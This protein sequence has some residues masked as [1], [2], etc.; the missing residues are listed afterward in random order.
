MFFSVQ[1]SIPIKNFALPSN[2]IYSTIFSLNWVERILTDLRPYSETFDAWIESNYKDESRLLRGQALKEALEWSKERILSP[3]DTNFLQTSQE[4]VLKTERQKRAILVKAKKKADQWIRNAKRF[5]GFGVILLVASLIIVSFLWLGL[6]RQNLIA[7]LERNGANALQQF[8]LAPIRALE[9]AIQNGRELKS[10]QGNSEPSNYLATNPILALQTIIDNISEVTEINTYQKG[11]KSVIFFQYGND[12]RLVAAGEDGTLR[13]WDANKGMQIGKELFAHPGGV[14]SVRFSRDQSK[15]VTAG[16]DGMVKLWSLSALNEQNAKPISEFKAHTSSIRNVRYSPNEELIATGGETDGMLKLWTSDGKRKWEVIAHDRGIESL[17]FSPDGAVI[18]TGGEDGYAKK[19]DLEGNLKQTFKHIEDDGFHG[20]VNSVTFSEKDEKNVACK[21]DKNSIFC[22]LKDGRMIATAGDNGTVKI[23]NLQGELLKTINAHIGTV[24]ASRFSIDNTQLATSS[25]DDFTS[26]NQSS[27]RIWNLNTGELLSEFN[28]H[29]GSVE[30]IRYSK[31]G[32]YLATSGKD[33]GKIIKWK[34]PITPFYGREEQHQGQVNSVRFSPDGK[35]IVTAGDDGTVRLWEQD[36]TTLKWEWEKNLP[37]MT[38][39][40]QVKFK[41]VRFNPGKPNQIAI[42]GS[43]GK[44]IIWDLIS[45]NL[46]NTIET[47]QKTIESI[48]FSSKGTYLASTG[49]GQVVQ[50]WDPNGKLIHNYDLKKIFQSGGRTYGVRFSLDEDDEKLAVVGDEGVAVLIDR[51]RG[52]LVRLKEESKE[53][54][55]ERPKGTVYAVG[56]NPDGKTFATAGDDGTIRQWD[57][58]GKQVGKGIDT[59]QG[60]IRNI[61]FS[62]DGE[63]LATAGSGGTVKLWNIKGRELANFRGHRG[64]VRSLDF[65]QKTGKS[66]VTVGDDGRPKIW[67]IRSL[68]ELLEQGCKKNN[69]QTND[70]LTPSRE[71]IC[72]Q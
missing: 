36:K 70:H 69:E 33:D 65:D 17:N 66:L 68:D 45:N 22:R 18:V 58:S 42:G 21:H 64:I 3:L 2:K 37:L 59:Y 20:G 38:D 67:S 41:S 50:L 1:L 16:V 62:A 63:L 24:E 43:D 34:V 61:R 29:Q 47:G 51:K 30:S 46:S 56:F 49:D 52:Q 10:L 4:N 8:N 12:E 54:S 32:K 28:G 57:F 39:T 6:A 13:M 26:P 53:E 25:G 72:P 11:V 14:N 7:S 44:V 40:P 55:K 71:K 48:N 31:D 35:K 19:W 15:F 60:S 27:V 5:I 23:W 9:S